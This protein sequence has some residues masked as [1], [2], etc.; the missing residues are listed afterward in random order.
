MGK[1]IVIENGCGEIVEKKSNKVIN[2][3]N[4]VIANKN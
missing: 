1:N 2:N 4:N 3:A